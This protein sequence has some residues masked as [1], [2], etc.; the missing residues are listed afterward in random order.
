MF[1]DILFNSTPTGFCNLTRY[2]TREAQGPDD[3][4]DGYCKVY[5]PGLETDPR[6]RIEKTFVEIGLSELGDLIY[7]AVGEYLAQLVHQMLHAFFYIYTCGF[8]HGCA[9]LNGTL[10]VCRVFPPIL[11]ML[12]GSA[13][14]LIELDLKLTSGLNLLVFTSQM[15]FHIDFK[16]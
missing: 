3:C 11:H 6:F 2:P 10:E 1:N 15:F 7:D 13:L 4:R 5:R 9:A 14:A 12:I 16:A 8:I